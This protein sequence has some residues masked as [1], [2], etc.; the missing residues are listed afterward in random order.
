MLSWRPLRLIRG[1]G[2]PRA[3]AAV[4]VVLAM[5]SPNSA[6][7]SGR[8]GTGIRMRRDSAAGV[9]APAA[10]RAASGAIVAALGCR[11]AGVAPVARGGARIYATGIVGAPVGSST[12]SLRSMS[13]NAGGGNRTLDVCMLRN[14]FTSRSWKYRAT[15]AYGCDVQWVSMRAMF[16][17]LLL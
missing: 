5:R 16:M 4:I 14:Q 17:T 7:I 11:S 12:Y 2:P 13:S 15:F 9:A 8:T 10:G 1:K 3:M 6:V